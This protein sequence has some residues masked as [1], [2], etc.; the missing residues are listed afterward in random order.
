MWN[1][2]QLTLIRH[3]EALYG[4]GPQD[5]TRKGIIQ[6]MQTSTA[7]AATLTGREKIMMHVS[8]KPR[9][10]HS[11]QLIS[12]MLTLSGSMVYDGNIRTE[13]LLDEVANF[14]WPFFRTLVEGGVIDIDGQTYEIDAELTNPGGLSL[15][16]YYNSDAVSR[17]N[18]NARTQLPQIFLQQADAMEKFSQVSARLK[19]LLMLIAKQ[20]RSRDPNKPVHDILVA[21]DAQAGVCAEAFS[22]GALTGIGTGESITLK[23]WHNRATV[24]RVGDQAKDGD[25]VELFTWFPK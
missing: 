10:Q 4:P 20:R 19:R 5:L 3:G 17:I 9:T 7:L 14:S 18:G 23:L 25:G 21:H 12:T 6:I 16:H 2:S 1:P 24:V 15:G 8:P 13:H 11:A 22:N